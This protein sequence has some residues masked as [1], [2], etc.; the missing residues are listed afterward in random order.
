MGLKTIFSSLVAVSSAV[1]AYVAVET[2]QQVFFACEGKV[3]QVELINPNRYSGHTDL[4][5]VLTSPIGHV[6]QYKALDVTGLGLADEARKMC[7]TGKPS[8]ELRLEAA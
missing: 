2:R 3:G 6:Q 4:R 5:I 7:R 8:P 1:A